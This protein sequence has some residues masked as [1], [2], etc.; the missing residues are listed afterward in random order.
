VSEDRD[1]AESGEKRKK[2]K[3]TDTEAIRDRNQRIREEAAAK[4]REKREGERERIAPTGQRLDA[5]EIVDDALARTTHVAG[6]WLKRNIN[7]LQ[8][9]VVLGVGAGIAWQIYAYRRD[10]NEGQT[11]DLLMKG[12]HAQR[13][14]VGEAAAGPDPITGLELP[15][16]P[17]KDDAERLK[18]AAEG[19]RAALSASGAP[20]TLARLGL[21]GVLYDQAKYKE[22]LTEY[23]TVRNSELAASDNGVKGRA[24][25]GIGLSEEAL[26]NLD[27]A[28]KAYRELENNA[29]QGFGPLGLYHQ[30]RIA[31]Q[32][33]D[34]EGAKKF[35]KSALEKIEKPKD[36]TEQPSY[37]EHAARELLA[38]IDPSAAA[39]LSPGRM[40][41]EQLKQLATQGA[42]AVGKDELSKEKLEELLKQLGQGAPPA[43]MPETP[44]PAPAPEAPPVA[45]PTAATPAPAATPK[46]APKLPTPAAPKP[47]TTPVAPATPTAEAPKAPATPAPAA[48]VP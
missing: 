41:P 48:S 38:I 9:V 17:F 26:K 4:R 35:L 36:P 33:G 11:T 37:T 27:G 8:W 3:G 1:S 16:K 43:P 2:R 29:G 14:P 22:A 24:I 44:P 30:G 20:G 13:A 12:V 7:V 46:A 10:K 6:N 45:P 40:T 42:G 18:A 19:Y 34:K 47:T 5:S 39:A 31:F 23:Q 21:A 32:K 28:A 25:E 15:Q